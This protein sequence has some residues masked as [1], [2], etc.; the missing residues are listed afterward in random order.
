MWRG[1]PGSAGG[2]W[3]GASRRSAAGNEATEVSA[4]IPAGKS[5]GG[6]VR[7]WPRIA[8][9]ALIVPAAVTLMSQQP[10]VCSARVEL[11]C[12]QLCR[13]LSWPAQQQILRSFSPLTRQS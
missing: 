8:A 13:W 1:V 2:G 12:P 3:R 9:G 10:Q 4:S 5:L 6:G 11:D 7:S